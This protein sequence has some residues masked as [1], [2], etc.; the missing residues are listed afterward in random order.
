MLLFSAEDD[1]K[2]AFPIGAIVG[3]LI[4]LVLIGLV[5]VGVFWKKIKG[6]ADSKQ[7]SVSKCVFN[8]ILLTL[9]GIHR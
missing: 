2:D 3:V 9:H 7:Y 4:V 5:F 8:A 6:M 1:E